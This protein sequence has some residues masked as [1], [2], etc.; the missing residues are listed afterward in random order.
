MQICTYACGF[1]AFSK[2]RIAEEARDTAYLLPFS[3]IQRRVAEAWDRG[4][5]E[6]CLQGGIHPDFTGGTYLRILRACK[7]A[8]SDIHVHAFSPLE[9]WHGAQTLGISVTA[10]LQ[11]LQE[12]GLGSLPGTAA[13]VLTDRVRGVICPDKLTTSE[14]LDVV[15]SAHAVGLNTTSTI[16]FGHVDSPSDWARHL[17]AIRCANSEVNSGMCEVRTDTDLSVLCDVDACSKRPAGSQSL[18]LCP[19]CTWKLLCFARAE[20]G[21]GQH[22]M[23]Q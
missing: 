4:A 16:M 5:T 21:L 8:V 15:G 7:E 14:W 2:G 17:L 6:V 19:S 13:E 11:Q 22:Y 23:N 12:A 20:H 1:C 3:E 10:F 18:S 9:V